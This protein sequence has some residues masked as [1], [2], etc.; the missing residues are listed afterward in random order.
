L[1]HPGFDARLSGLAFSEL[2]EINAGEKPLNDVLVRTVELAKS[3]LK[4]PIEASVTLI[5]SHGPTTP[6]FT[7]QTA[8][9]LDETQYQL[10]YGPCLAAAEAGQLVSIP[11]M[12]ADTRW[13]QFTADA[14]NY[15]VHSSLSVPLP[16][17]RQV[18]G[19]LNL[20]CA[21]VHG[22]GDEIVELAQKFGDYA[23]VAIAHTTLYLSTRELADQMAQALQSRAIIEQAKGILIGQRRCHADEAFNILVGLSQQSHQKLRDVA[24]ALVEHTLAT[25]PEH[26]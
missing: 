19:A 14:E 9:D 26:D 18:I 23:A 1:T 16:V 15:G 21:Q 17:Q 22:F 11:D 25:Q 6:A 4:A 5:N 8:I 20:Y 7:G 2:N 13:P 12:A 3:V 24:K 10:G